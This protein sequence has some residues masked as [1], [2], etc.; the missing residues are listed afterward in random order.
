MVRTLLSPFIAL[1][2]PFHL[3]PQSSFDLVPLVVARSIATA[4]LGFAVGISASIV[5]LFSPPLA[6]SSLTLV[7]DFPFSLFGL[8]RRF[9]L[10]QLVTRPMIDSYVPPSAI[11]PSKLT[12]RP[13]HS[14][15]FTSSRRKRRKLWAF[16]CPHSRFFSP[17]L[18]TRPSASTRPLRRASGPAIAAFVD[19]SLVFFHCYVLPSKH[20][21]EQRLQILL[22]HAAVS[23]FSVALWTVVGMKDVYAAIH[24][25]AAKI[26]KGTFLIYILFSLLPCT[27]F[28]LQSSTA[29]ALFHSPSAL[30]NFD[31]RRA[32]LTFFPLPPQLPTTPPPPSRP[33]SPPPPT[34]RSK[35]PTSSSRRSGYLFTMSVARFSPSLS[36]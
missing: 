14:A 36:G 25:V 10:L 6:P 31:N 3:F 9:T 8:S 16:S 21:D 2:D 20:T 15:F 12:V 1:A 28:S 17:A 22:A 26:D 29:D 33:P 11:S 18:P 13:H 35:P 30:H 24:G 23:T 27:R 4:G 34:P 32:R 7:V 19:T 5:S